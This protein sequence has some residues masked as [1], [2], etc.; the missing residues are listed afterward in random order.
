MIDIW[1]KMFLFLFLN[2][3]KKKN[4]PVLNSKFFITS[5]YVKQLYILKKIKFSGV[6]LHTLRGWKYALMWFLVLN[7]VHSL[8]CDWFVVVWTPLSTRVG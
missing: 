7:W 6:V 8:W 3:S 5:H 4:L 2:C 1:S